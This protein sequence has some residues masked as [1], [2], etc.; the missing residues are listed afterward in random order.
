MPLPPPEPRVPFQSSGSTVY[1]QMATR[2]ADSKVTSDYEGVDKVLTGEWAFIKVSGDIGINVKTL[3]SWS[4]VEPYRSLLIG[5][6]L[7]LTD[8]KCTF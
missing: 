1:R 8:N 5:F 6:S 7:T 3:W 2:Y 4:I